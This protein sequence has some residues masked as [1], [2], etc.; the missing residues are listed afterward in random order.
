MQRARTGHPTLKCD[1]A[2]PLLHADCDNDACSY[3]SS[4][5]P[6]RHA[7]NWK[8]LAVYAA[9]SVCVRRPLSGWLLWTGVRCA[10]LC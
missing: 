1:N 5:H 2:I 4:N 7:P 8:C 9:G 10:L 3:K 6:G